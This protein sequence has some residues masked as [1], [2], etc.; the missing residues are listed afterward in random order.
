MS[1]GFERRPKPDHSTL[2]FWY[3]PG[4]NS[5][6]EHGS[7]QRLVALSGRIDLFSDLLQG[8]LVNSDS[9]HDRISAVGA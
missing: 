4:S 9:D 1:V 8:V 3:V 6:P 7:H 5:V 2:W